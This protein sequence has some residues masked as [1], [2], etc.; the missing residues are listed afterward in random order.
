MGGDARTLLALVVTLWFIVRS[1]VPKLPPGNLV[2]REQREDQRFTEGD[3]GTARLDRLTSKGP[4][5]KRCVVTPPVYP[6]IHDEAG[7]MG[8]VVQKV[9]SGVRCS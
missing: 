6:P 4:A 3:A 5:W 2:R 1:R 8:G 7:E 9:R